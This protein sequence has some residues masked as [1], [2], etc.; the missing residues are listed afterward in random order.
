MN[1]RIVSCCMVMAIFGL[2]FTVGCGDS[3]PVRCD[4]TGTVTLDGEPL[5]TGEILFLPAD[6]QGPSDTCQIVAGAFE[7][8]VTPGSKKVEISSTKEIPATE[9][10]GMPDYISLVPAKY[11]TATTLTA[12]VTEGGIE[13]ATF[14][15]EGGN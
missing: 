2:V 7:G 8:E 10:G 14:A 11:N 1:R 6:G 12:E 15:L 13:P 4:V 9:T 3:G 5:E